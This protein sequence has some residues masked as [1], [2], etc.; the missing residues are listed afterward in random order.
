M[1]KRASGKWFLADD[2][3][4]KIDAAGDFATLDE[5]RAMESNFTKPVQTLNRPSGG[6]DDKKDVSRV[7]GS[8]GKGQKP[9]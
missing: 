8:L 3:G 5:A 9:K 6:T 4:V 7:S 2:K 1:I